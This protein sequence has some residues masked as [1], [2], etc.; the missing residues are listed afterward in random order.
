MGSPKG[1]SKERKTPR[2]GKLQVEENSKERKTPRRDMLPGRK[3]SGERRSQE[4][5]APRRE[6]PPK[7]A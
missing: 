4:R 6:G 1:N 7:E 2:R 3:L 5:D